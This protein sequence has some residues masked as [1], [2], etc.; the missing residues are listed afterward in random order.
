M[1][2]L[3]LTK[4]DFK[5]SR[6]WNWLLY[7]CTRWA[8]VAFI[9]SL[10]FA[11]AFTAM[12]LDQYLLAKVLYFISIVIPALKF[13]LWEEAR[14]TTNRI[15]KMILLLIVL[16]MATLMFALCWKWTDFRNRQIHLNNKEG[17]NQ[18]QGLNKAPSTQSPLAA[19]KGKVPIQPETASTLVEKEDNRNKRM[20]REQLAVFIT[21][22]WK[23]DGYARGVNLKQGQEWISDYNNWQASVIKF[24]TK[25]L[26]SSYAEQFNRPE[27]QNLMPRMVETYQGEGMSESIRAKIRYL[28]KVIDEQK[29]GLPNIKTTLVAPNALIAT[30]G[31]NG[32]NTVV[33]GNAMR[34]ITPDVSALLDRLAQIHIGQ[35]I[36]VK[37]DSS[38]EASEYAKKITKY[39]N[40]H[41]VN[42]FIDASSIYEGS[43]GYG[44]Y[45]DP[46]SGIVKVGK[47]PMQ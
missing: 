3:Q 21:E 39:L 38:D 9:A 32:N 34:Q 12:S 7:Q 5:R 45:I 24:L 19:N 16:I 36:E 6:F 23:Y 30:Q 2:R 14:A 22:G 35:R 40:S 29:V 17:A 4:A 18:S 1:I 31:Q 13:L 8:V 15:E 43:F 42:A 26:D 33:L 44:L 11:A 37:T 28:E 20:I 46:E 41:G 10:L 27:S 47:R 25:N